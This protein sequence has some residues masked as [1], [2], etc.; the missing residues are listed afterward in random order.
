[1]AKNWTV[2]EAVVAL[3]KGNHE[4]IV[5]IGKRFPL[6]H[7]LI[8][9]AL[10]GNVQATFNLLTALPEHITCN[11][12]NTILKNGIE[13][14]EADDSDVEVEENETDT[15][16][17]KAK[18]K[19][20]AKVEESDEETDYSSMSGKQL[21][22]E[23]RKHKLQKVMKEKYN[24]KWNKE[25]MVDCL[26]KYAGNDESEDTEEVEADEYQEGAYDDMSAIE[27][28][29]EC[30]KR[31]L[32]VAPKKNADFYIE[33]LE[34]D[35]RAKLKAKTEESDEAEDDWDEADEEP[36]VEV[37]GKKGSK[38]KKAEAKKSTK[39]KVEEV[40]EDDDWDI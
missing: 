20:K 3:E 40:D 24:N 22:E 11:K 2:K 27:L 31:G 32:K 35:D 23:L 18:T 26:E 8:C 19:A 16:A 7:H 12:V 6:L 9:G 13:E 33:K 34:A 15:K 30:K 38:E 21:T 4:D 37:K 1:M 10:S 14:V 17:T 28:F 39:A 5:D 25:N 29:K 36:K